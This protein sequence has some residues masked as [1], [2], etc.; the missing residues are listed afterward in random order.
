[1]VDRNMERW[2]KQRNPKK[3]KNS[4][5]RNIGTNND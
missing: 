2:K 1:M 5:N 3:N 4:K